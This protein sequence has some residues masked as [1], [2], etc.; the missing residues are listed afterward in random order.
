MRTSRFVYLAGATT[1]VAWPPVLSRESY[2]AKP[3]P[4]AWLQRGHH[5]HDDT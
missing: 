3:I 2:A 4:A 5:H 1:G